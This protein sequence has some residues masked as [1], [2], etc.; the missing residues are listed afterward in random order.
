MAS[1]NGKRR[2]DR[3]ARID[4]DDP[5]YDGDRRIK[6]SR[7]GSPS[8]TSVPDLPKGYVCHRC[9]ERGHHIDHC[10]QRG[11]AIAAR[12]SAG[13]ARAIAEA[14]RQHRLERERQTHLRG[15]E[16]A[17]QEVIRGEELELAHIKQL[18]DENDRRE[19]AI[20]ARF[21]A[22]RMED[23]KRETHRMT[24]PSSAPTHLPASHL[25]APAPTAS[26]LTA[27]HVIAP[28]PLVPRA[29]PIAAPVFSP[30]FRP[31]FRPDFRPEFRPEGYSAFRPEAYHNHSTATA[32]TAATRA[33]AHI[34]ASAASVAATAAAASRVDTEAA[35]DQLAL[36]HSGFALD[37]RHSEM[38]LIPSL[39]GDVPI[40]LGHFSREQGR[41]LLNS[42]LTARQRGDVMHALLAP[43]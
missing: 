32:A 20:L 2:V 9:H 19:A 23:S 28:A 3:V 27:S 6:R 40:R 13:D 41:I 38:A 36:N 17:R 16:L 22:R 5:N 14:A 34:A 31:E 18:K 8:R 39:R 26:H 33:S 25:T 21:A 43:R 35:L 10:P 4:F 7:T 42:L 15:I 30:E 24:I 29:S 37:I 11:D 1:D 12:P